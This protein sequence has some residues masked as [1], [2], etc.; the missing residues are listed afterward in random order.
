M[1]DYFQTNAAD[2]CCGCGACI[3]ACPNG[4]LEFL[5]ND[6]GFLYPALKE[7]L[8]IHC[9]RCDSICPISH[10]PNGGPAIKLFAVQNK[11]LP[12]LLDS[13]SGGVFISLAKYVI[14]K[15]GIVIGCIWNDNMEPVL[16]PTDTLDGLKAMQGSKYVFSSAVGIYSQ[17]KKYLDSGKLV[18]FTGAPCQCVGLLKYLNKDY[19][20]LYLMDFVCHGMPSQTVFNAYKKSLEEK[21]SATITDFRFRDKTKHG[22]AKAESYRIND[23][24][25]Y[26]HGTVSPYSY[27]FSKGFF[28]RY[29]C[30]D[31]QFQTKIRYSDFTVCDFWGYNQFYNQI[32][33]TENGVSAIEINSSK[34][35]N[36]FN[37]IKDEFVFHEVDCREVSNNNPRIDNRKSFLIPKE[38]LIIYKDL[39]KYGWNYV[40]KQ[41]L[42]CKHKQFYEV[43]YALPKSFRLTIKRFRRQLS[44]RG[45]IQI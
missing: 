9:N 20:N 41:Y 37:S 28:Q 12:L 30:Y 11:D 43:W 36:M 14:E 3:A 5:P 8:C 15:K 6:E 35:L 39:D 32:V 7:D 21:H 34:G 42:Q 29:S 44:G 19:T 23:K 24:T 25:K 10:M 4:S 22:W 45:L 40:S 27:G 17:T 16:I 18:L 26:V 38:R 2:Q 31:C 13:S 1:L 33:Q